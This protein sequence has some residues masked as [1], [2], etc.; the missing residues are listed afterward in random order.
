MATILVSGYSFLSLV[1]PVYK[2]IQAKPWQKMTEKR[3]FCHF[4]GIFLSFCIRIQLLV[5]FLQKNTSSWHPYFETKVKK[6]AV[7]LR[8]TKVFFSRASLLNKSHLKSARE[9]AHSSNGRSTRIDIAPPPGA[10][11]TYFGTLDTSETKR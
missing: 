7:L 5:K 2:L 9:N 1:Q 4:V 6:K 3:D 8:A 10:T 11:T